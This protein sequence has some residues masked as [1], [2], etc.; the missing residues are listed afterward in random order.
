MV[1]SVYKAAGEANTQAEK[2]GEASGKETATSISFWAIDEKGDLIQREY[3][4][5]LEID[6]AWVQGFHYRFCFFLFL[7][8]PTICQKKKVKKKKVD[9]LQLKI[10]S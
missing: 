10:M 4:I 2:A 5:P 7:F 9:A 8:R 1:W 3:T 6:N